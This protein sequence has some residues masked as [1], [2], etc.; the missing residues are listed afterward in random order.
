MKTQ[1]G[2]KRLSRQRGS[3][4]VELALLLSFVLMPLL[5]GVI[6]FGQILLAQAVVTRAAREGALAASRNQDAAGAAN[7][8]MQS[9]GYDLGLTH[10][11][12]AGS[13]ASGTPVTVTVG[14]DTSGMVIIPWY[15]IN[16]NLSRVNASA[17]ERQS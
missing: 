17:T 12:T 9:A 3:L 2:N 16:E 14:Y 15:N 1:S 6:D 7:L 10:V 5:V 13:G 8:Y 11:A 4:A